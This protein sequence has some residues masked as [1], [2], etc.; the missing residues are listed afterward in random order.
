MS[1]QES[2]ALRIHRDRAKRRAARRKRII[3]WCSIP[4]LLA[5]ALFAGKRF[6][7][8]AIGWRAS[9]IASAGDEFA[10]A[11]KWNEAAGKYRAALQLD[12]LGYHPLSSA[13]RLASKLGRPEAVDL[14]EQ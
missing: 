2:F 11:E 3:I 7:H 12:P 9:Q 10:K 5:L 13:A 8:W 14:W 6:Y 1:E 4:V